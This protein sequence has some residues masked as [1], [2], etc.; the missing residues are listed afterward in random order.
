MYVGTSI[1]SILLVILSAK[2]SNIP[3]LLPNAHT[4]PLCKIATQESFIVALNSFQVL[5]FELNA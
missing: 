1:S 5:M 3:F 4:F 2:A